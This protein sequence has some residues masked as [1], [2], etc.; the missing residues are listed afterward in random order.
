[1]VAAVNGA[2]VGGGFEI[3]LAC[4]L[5]VA[6]PDAWFALPEPQRGIVP[7]GGGAIRLSLELPKVIANA[8]LLAGAKLT[9][10]DAARWGLVNEIVP[11]EDLTGA[12]LGL[13]AAISKAAPLAISATMEMARTTRRMLEAPAWDVSD[14]SV[15]FIRL[16]TDAKEGPRAFAEKR[17]PVWAGE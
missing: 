15:R 17:S 8:V 16:T 13:A 11:R 2:A 10:G 14:A 5:V 3:V 7:G 1:L 6:V 9:A 12:A 4:D